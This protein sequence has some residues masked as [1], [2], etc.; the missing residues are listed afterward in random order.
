[1]GTDKATLEIFGRPMALW[2]A[3]AMRSSGVARIVALG[4][5]AGLG[6]ELVDD[7]P[8]GEGPLAA[9][10]G[11]LALGNPILVCPC[12][13]PAVTPAVFDALIERWL[14]GD[15]PVVLA[16]S[17]HLEPL[18]GVYGPEIRPDLVA[19]FV[20]GVRGPKPALDAAQ[21]VTVPVD[22]RV[23]LNVNTPADLETVRALL[24]SRPES[25]RRQEPAE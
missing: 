12:D 19:A 24:R 18:I 16:D 7:E 17:G 25:R 4:G 20:D 5:S 6:L 10:L 21:F 14:V 13:V 2:V 3:D 15:V 11:G 9:L 23:V 8:G 1:M 22:P